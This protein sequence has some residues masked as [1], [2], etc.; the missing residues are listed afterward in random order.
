MGVD[1][2]MD[3]DADIACFYRLSSVICI[4]RNVKSILSAPFEVSS[5]VPVALI[6]NCLGGYK[7][8]KP[9]NCR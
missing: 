8:Y 2:D 3:I 7:G 5:T 1:T 6:T 4:G 9:L